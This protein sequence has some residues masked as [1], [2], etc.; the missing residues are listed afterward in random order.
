L[1]PWNAT[2]VGLTATAGS[3]TTISATDADLLHGGPN[4][5]I[6]DF[7]LVSLDAGTF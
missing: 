2:T 1:P 3:G 7:T 6:T 4:A 5:Y